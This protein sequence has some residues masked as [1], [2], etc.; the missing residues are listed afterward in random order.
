MAREPRSRRAGVLVPLFSMASARSWGIGEI[1]DLHA[2]SRW[3]ASA[4][5]RV[6]QLLPINEVPVGE[7]SPYSALSSMAID[8]QFITL[9]RV[10]DFLELGGEE[11]LEPE[12]RERLDAVRSHAA[13]DY[14]D[15]RA[16]KQ[17]ALRRAFVRFR[18]VELAGGTRRAAAFRAYVQDQAWWL[19]DYALFRALHAQSGERPWTEWPTPVRTRQPGALDRARGELADDILYRQYVQW[20]ADDQWA[21]ARAAAGGVA[22]FGDL[23]FMVSGDSAD[24]WARQDEFRFDASVGVPPDAFSTTGQDWGLPVYRWD[25]LAGRDFDWLRDR[26][27]RNAALFDG[28]RID[29]LVGFY[30]TYFWPHDGTDPGF[31]PDTEEAQTALGERVLSV[32]RECGAEI[33]AEDLGTVPEFVRESLARLEVPGFK[34]LRWER[35]WHQ[36]GQPFRDPVGY[37]RSAVA[38]SGTHDTEPMEVWWEQAGREE[39]E[40]V[41]A[42][43][44]IRER[45][46]DEDRAV[47]VEHAGMTTAL[48]EALLET[49]YASGADLLILPVQDI[50]GWRDRINRPATVNP[51]NWTWRL[52]WP[53]DRWTTEPAAMAMAT[54]LR[55]WAAR[56]NR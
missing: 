29:H 7:A 26:A 5:L 33:V 30:R 22:L 39:R 43:P 32:F 27:R 8:P 34:V 23:P 47:A 16:L 36:P 4:G 55:E 41:L 11:R 20:V 24:L 10:D 17:T 44:S 56:H 54:Q 49:L 28:Y 53:A 6:L 25:V 38:T 40:A 45:L 15:V 50:F 12:L 48:R 14:A 3:L 37:P 18:S 1:G 31:T 42:V 13:I 51:A 21:D 19:D 46:D 9:D 2:L 35:E 52:P